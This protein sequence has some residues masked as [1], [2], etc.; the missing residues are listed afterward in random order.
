[1]NENRN[2]DQSVSGTSADSSLMKSWISIKDLK[3][4][5][6]GSKQKDPERTKNLPL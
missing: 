4:M 3:V 5:V 2:L 6:Q 1:M